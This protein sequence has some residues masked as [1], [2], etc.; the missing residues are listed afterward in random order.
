MLERKKLKFRKD[1]VFFLGDVEEL[2]FLITK[3]YVICHTCRKIKLKLKRV[4]LNILVTQNMKF[5]LV[6]IFIESKLTN[7]ENFKFKKS[8]FFLH[9]YTNKYLSKNVSK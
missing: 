8:K 6:A 1:R 3:I 2:T 7:L 4:M 9:A 5:N